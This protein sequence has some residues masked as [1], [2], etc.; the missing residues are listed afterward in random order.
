[1]VILDSACAIRGHS[2]WCMCDQ[3]VFW[4]VRAR[5]W[6]IMDRARAIRWIGSVTMSPRPSALGDC[7]RGN[8][9]TFARLQACVRA[10][11]TR[12]AGDPRAWNAQIP[13]ASET[14]SARPERC[15][16]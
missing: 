3:E 10:A 2:G 9:G 11:S 1:M 15:H 7:P 8:A 6:G 13:P 5:S 4:I 12:E 16:I 14:H